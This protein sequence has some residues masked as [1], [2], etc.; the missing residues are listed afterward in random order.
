MRGLA[1]LLVGFVFS[2]PAWAQA[3]AAGPAPLPELAPFAVRPAIT[4]NE[5]AFLEELLA[6]LPPGWRVA[7]DAFGSIVLR[8]AAGGAAESPV[9]LLVAVGVDEPGYVVSQIRDD[10]WLRV[11]FV[12]RSVPAGFHLL[13]EGRPVTVLTRE[14]PVAG[15]ITVN[16]VHFRAPRPDVIG[17]EHLFLDVGADSPEDVDAL[18]IELLDAVSARE[19][20]RLHDGRVAGPSVGTRAATLALLTVLRKG[21]PGVVGAGA[22]RGLAFAFVAQSVPAAGARGTDPGPLGR[23]GEGVLRRLQPEKA[24]IL[25]AGHGLDKAVSGP[26][27]LGDQHLGYSAIELRVANADTPVETVAPA[28]LQAFTAAVAAEVWK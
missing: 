5:A 2:L 22:S 6:L 24:L 21:P 13:R 23:G 15:V 20:V 19:I 7:R 26:S 11:H 9:R 17:E 14:G 4:G 18:G 12:G 8:E 3:P 25:R 27:T 10:G 16:S 1:A 28:D